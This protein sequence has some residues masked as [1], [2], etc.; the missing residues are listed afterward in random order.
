MLTVAR[1]PAGNR[2]RKPQFL[3]LERHGDQARAGHLDLAVAAHD[4]DKLVELFG[5]AGGFESESF[6]AGIDD[7]GA[8][9]LRFLQNGGAVLHASSGC[10]AAPSRGLRMA[11]PSGRLPA[12]R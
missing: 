2:R 5:I 1:P 9:D 10:A 7:A 4:I 12:G 11:R 8:E 3:H 6:D